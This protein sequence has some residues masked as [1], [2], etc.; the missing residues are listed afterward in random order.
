MYVQRKEL[1]RVT[2]DF[3]SYSF[4]LLWDLSLVLFI[5]LFLLKLLLYLCLLLLLL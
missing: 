4:F 3:Y 5:L 2:G 1:T